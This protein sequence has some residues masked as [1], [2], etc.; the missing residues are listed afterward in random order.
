MFGQLKTLSIKALVWSASEN[1][2]IALLSFGVFALM[3]RMLEP[4]HF[5]IVAL[6]GVFILTFNLVVGHSFADAIVQRAEIEQEHL[7]TAF[8]TNLAIALALTGLCHLA[9]PAAARWFGEPA[10]A[11]VL[12]W[13]S[14]VMP[15][16]A[17]GI[18][19]TA[20]FRRELR[21]RS[22][23]LRS[24][25]GRTAGAAA[26]VGMA[27]GGLGVWSLVGQQLAGF[28]ITGL[29]MCLASPWRPRLR[30]SLSHLR[31]LWSFG[32]HV[33]AS[34]LIAGVGEQAMNLLVG[35]FYGS[36]AL[37]YF[38]IAWRITQLMR[39]LIASS[40]YHVGFSAF[41]RLQDDRAAAGRAFLQAT[42]MSCLLGFPIG[43]GM[44]VLAEPLVH[45]LFGAKWSD[46]AM[47]LAILA[48]QMFP[49]FYA[50]FFTACY[51]ALG[52][53]S[54]TLVLS[55]LYIVLGVAIVLA[56]TPLGIAAMAAGWVVKSILLLPV[57]LVLLRRLLGIGIRPLVS[58]IGSPLVSALAMGAALL[59]LNLGLGDRLGDLAFLAVAVPIGA[60][61][62]LAAA[63]AISPDLIRVAGRTARLMAAPQRASGS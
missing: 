7:D 27:L 18:V 29:A 20:L 63:F 15:L 41:A 13:L 9:A 21:F 57:Q 59:G 39:S 23:A 17:I 38:N 24:L 40:V 25:A 43:I 50:M 33:S 1:L 5:G 6:A 46:S 54:W 14:W 35:T 44:A 22:I 10:L 11:D 4:E 3:A 48:F 47:L 26:G 53:A 51:R 34:Q 60:A 31:D 8:W 49:A 2:G 45:V 52:K 30:F 28:A 36:V 37:G 32:F 55:A 61:V 19:Q 42:R 16:N 62:Y 58:P 56:C 12:P